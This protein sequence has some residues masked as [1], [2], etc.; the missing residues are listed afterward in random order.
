VVYFDYPLMI[1]LYI[2]YLIYLIKIFL[3][4]LKMIINNF[5]DVIIEASILLHILIYFLFLSFSFLSL[6]FLF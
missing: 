2:Y 5:K 6:S 4:I 3:I 1:F